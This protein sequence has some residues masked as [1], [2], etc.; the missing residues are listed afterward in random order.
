[1]HKIV[2]TTRL[3]NRISLIPTLRGIVPL[4]AAQTAVSVKLEIMGN[5]GGA[6]F[7]GILMMMMVV[8]MMMLMNREYGKREKKGGL[9]GGFYI[10]KTEQ[11]G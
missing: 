11:A 7:R 5:W 4:A 2:T 6:I 8:M 9:D 3:T 10:K 1:M